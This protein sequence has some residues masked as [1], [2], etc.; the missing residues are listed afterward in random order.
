MQIPSETPSKRKSKLKAK[1]VAVVGAQ[2]ASK[3]AA[4]TSAARAR[5]RAAKNRVNAIIS[6]EDRYRLIAEAAYYLAEQRGFDGGDTIQDWLQ[7]E[8]KIDSIYKVKD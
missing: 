6:S 5:T 3:K 7:A 4:G 1:Q 8:A 2:V